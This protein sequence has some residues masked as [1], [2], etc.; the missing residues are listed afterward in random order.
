[1]QTPETIEKGRE[2]KEGGNKIPM[3]STI[4]PCDFACTITHTSPPIHAS[5]KTNSERAYP[6][7]LK[8][9]SKKT[10]VTIPSGFPVSPAADLQSIL[11]LK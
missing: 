4:V 8:K 11:L 3:T 5:L 9:K 2:K 7:A 10:Y 1:M 6:K